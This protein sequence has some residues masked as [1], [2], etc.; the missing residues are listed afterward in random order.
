MALY[1]LHSSPSLF[2]W[3]HWGGP[4]HHPGV[5]G[6]LGA[7]GDLQVSKHKRCDRG[8]PLAAHQWE[9]KLLQ[10]RPTTLINH[11][12]AGP[13]HS[14][15]DF[16]QVIPWW[17][18]LTG[19]W[20]CL[21]KVHY[22]GYVCWQKASCKGRRKNPCIPTAI[23][24]KGMLSKS[25]WNEVFAMQDVLFERKPPLRHFPKDY[26]T[27]LFGKKKKGISWEKMNLSSNSEDNK[28]QNWYLTDI[29]MRE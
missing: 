22:T 11:D 29:K 15:V 5:L 28:W 7:R 17:S 2:P 3:S 19:P 24:N 25:L 6:A 8:T 23:L 21:G 27:M 18:P 12:G 13:T 1:K 16:D 10:A 20:W 4:S 9:V 26:L 14:I